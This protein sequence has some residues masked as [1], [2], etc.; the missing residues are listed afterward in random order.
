M[1]VLTAREAQEQAIAR[2]LEK[3][4]QLCEINCALAVLTSASSMS[5][6]REEFI[7]LVNKEIELYNSMVDKKGTDGEKDAIKA[8]RLQE[9]KLTILVKSLIVMR[10]LQC[11]LKKL[12]LCSKILRR[13]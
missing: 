6:E 9:R 2:A 1:T 12:M 8:Y 11:L 5:R 7:G 13:K 10:F 4:D 3:R